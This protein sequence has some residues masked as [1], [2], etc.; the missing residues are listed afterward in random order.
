MEHGE[1]KS[2]KE[3]DGSVFF[4]N[5]ELKMGKVPDKPLG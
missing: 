4:P 2:F 3:I 1:D 5:Q